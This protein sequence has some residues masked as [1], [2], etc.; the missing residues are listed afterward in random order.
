M[1]RVHLYSILVLLMTTAALAQSDRAAINGTV[2]D[3]TGAVVTDALV[4]VVSTQTGYRREVRSNATGQYLVPGLLVGDY[5]VTITKE[6]FRTVKSESIK[7]VV[8]Q[9]LTL[10]VSMDVATG[11]I[12]V[13]VL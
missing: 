3:P 7:L 13:M 4:E 11:V 9:I 1:P 10:D 12:Q 8:G 6:G 5:S 2:T